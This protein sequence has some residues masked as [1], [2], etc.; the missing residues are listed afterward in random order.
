MKTFSLTRRQLFIIGSFSI[1][2][3]FLVLPVH[4]FAASTGGAGLPYENW[5]NRLRESATGPVAYTVS[6]IGIIGAGAML[7]FGGEINGFLKSIV[8]IVLVMSLLVGANSMMG[9]FFGAG[10]EITTGHASE[11]G[12]ALRVAFLVIAG[13][14]AGFF[15]NKCNVKSQKQESLSHGA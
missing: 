6:I 11:L 3:L 12:N 4:A 13:M 2:A 8:F 1:L 9:S 7:I 10:A 15:N 14:L 5:L